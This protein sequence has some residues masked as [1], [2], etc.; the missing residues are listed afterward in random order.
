MSP[1]LR[2]WA[3]VIP[4]VAWLWLHRWGMIAPQ[5]DNNWYSHWITYHFDYL[6]K[7]IFPLWDPYRAWGW[8][9]IYDT[10]FFGDLNPLFLIIPLLTLCHVPPFAAFNVF[11]VSFFLL[12]S[13]G[14]YLF[15]RCVWGRE[16]PALLAYAMFMFSMTG[17]LLFSQ[18]TVMSMLFSSAWFFYFMSGYLRSP[19]SAGQKKYFAGMVLV[20]MLVVSTYVPFFFVVSISAVMLAAL[21][22]SPGVF[23]AVGRKSAVFA[24]ERPVLCCLGFCSVVLACL[25]GL[26]FYLSSH[27]GDI[28]LLFERNA[29]GASSSVTVPLGMISHSSLAAQV[30]LGELF[31]DQDF[32]MNTFCYV[33]VFLAVLLSLGGLTR[34]D[35]RQ[36]IIFIAAFFIL[37]FALAGVTPVHAFLYQHAG[38]FR[39]FRNLYFLGPLLML[40]LVALAVGQLPSFLEAR[41]DDR[42]QRA[43]Y[44]AFIGLVHAG[45]L[46][47]LLSQERVLW[48]TYATVISSAAVFT[49][50]ALGFFDRRR[51]LLLAGL[52][53]LVM[54]QPSELIIKYWS[55]WSPGT[56]DMRRLDDPPFVYTRP[57][58][59]EIPAMEKGL[60]LVPKTRK[61]ESGFRPE[62]F[63]GTGFAY[64]LYSNIAPE[65]LQEYV[66]H[67]FMVYDQAVWMDGAAPDWGRVRAS[68][69]GLRGPAWVHDRNAAAVSPGEGAGDQVL[70]VSGPSELLR[71]TEFD[72]NHVR[73]V[74]NF[75]TR[76]FVVFNDSYHPGWRVEV[77]G[78]ARPLFRANAAFKGV[79]VEAGRQEV[80]F[81]FGSVAVLGWHWGLVG[82]FAAWLGYAWYLLVRGA[83]CA[84]LR[85]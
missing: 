33:P 72:P 51:E 22:V 63:Y 26:A 34:M 65:D 40:T 6:A 69:R 58:R 81:V 12:G 4:F 66:S 1:A 27:R 7:G 42:A 25:P 46:A 29:F 59:G 28:V 5:V 74:T 23:I 21:L 68:L 47:V 30:S 61:D 11:L 75:S 71:V 36:R 37:L 52:L 77:N 3:L 8:P 60:G 56:V 20:M 83:R 80:A 39:L 35:I 82:L 43:W 53:G 73:L 50:F 14:F 48:T 41:P 15:V 13:V 79:W 45:W 2:C 78:Q 17:E 85:G 18:L 19:L 64:L 16:L 55:T 31:S 10:R 38:I 49:A 44:I 84:V 54:L 32:V 67:K 57:L 24:R 70:A 9:D 62:G 76:K